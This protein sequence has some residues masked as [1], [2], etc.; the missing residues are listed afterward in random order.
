MGTGLEAFA[1]YIFAAAATILTS[2]NSK[3]EPAPQPPVAAPTPPAPAV[4]PD[5]SPLKTMNA[6]LAAAQGP[7][8]TLLTGPGGVDSKSLNLGRN[9]LLG[10]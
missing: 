7:S 3:S 10:E 1:P 4:A 5:V 2:G 9:L 6:A 8:S